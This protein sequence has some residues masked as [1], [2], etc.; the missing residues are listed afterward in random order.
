MGTIP[1]LT[2]ELARMRR[3]PTEFAVLSSNAKCKLCYKKTAVDLGHP[4][5]PANAGCWC[6]VHG[7]LFFDSVAI[8]PTER[9]KPYEIQERAEA[10]KRHI[11]WQKRQDAKKSR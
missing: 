8:P 2:A 3:N 5:N 11:A 9:L 7:W 4:L 10:E 1:A 6:P